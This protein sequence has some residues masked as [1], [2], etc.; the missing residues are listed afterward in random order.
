MFDDREQSLVE[1]FVRKKVR[2]SHRS[3]VT[4]IV[5]QLDNTLKSAD[6]RKLKQLKHSLAKKSSILARLNEEMIEA[7]EEEQ[8]EAEIEQA[9]LIR[10][11]ISL[12]VISIEE[13]L[14]AI[15]ASN[16]KDGH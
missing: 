1:G 16:E 8:L 3:S 7:T 10:E 11:K 12:A 5:G 14:E 2:A 15:K 4:R 6:M 13:T 9:D